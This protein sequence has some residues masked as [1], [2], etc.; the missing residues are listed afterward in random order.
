MHSRGA[1]RVSGKSSMSHHSTLTLFFSTP[2][3]REQLRD[4]LNWTHSLLRWEDAKHFKHHL[5]RIGALSKALST[6]SEKVEFKEG[7][8]QELD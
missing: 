1:S 2:R 6:K 8:E 7:E 3:A 5:S 4:A